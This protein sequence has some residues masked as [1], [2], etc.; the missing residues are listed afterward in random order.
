MPSTR[1]F[2]GL[3]GHGGG[4]CNLPSVGSSSLPPPAS[5]AGV[6]FGFLQVARLRSPSWLPWFAWVLSGV[7]RGADDP[8]SCGCRPAPPREQGTLAPPPPAR[9]P[10]PALGAKA[11]VQVCPCLLSPREP[12]ESLVLAVSWDSGMKT[13]HATMHL[14][15]GRRPPQPDIAGWQAGPFRALPA[16]G[17]GCECPAPPAAPPQQVPRGAQPRP[18]P[19]GGEPQTHTAVPSRVTGD[20]RP[21]GQ[22]GRQTTPV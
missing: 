21:A 3:G 11:H 6:I 9:P 20:G 18:A 10:A 1:A 2:S 7:W 15:Q 13:C 19:R 12:L 4:T 14:A 16:D 5:K 17:G 8:R 22:G